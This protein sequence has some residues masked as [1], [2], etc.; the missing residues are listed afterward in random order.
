MGGTIWVFGYGSLIYRPGFVYS[1]RV[2]GYI[3]DYKRVFYQGSTD[4]RGTQEFPGR[5]VTLEPLQGAVTWGV[6]YALSG[7]PAEQEAT[8]QYLEE[9]EKQYDVRRVVDLMGS[10][11]TVFQ[12]PPPSDF[13][14][15]VQTASLKA[16]ADA[17]TL[18]ASLPGNA[19]SNT[20]ADGCA[21]EGRANSQL[22]TT[23]AMLQ[24]V[25]RSGG[26]SVGSA[27]TDSCS[28]LSQAS[29][30]GGSNSTGA[31]SSEESDSSGGGG[32]NNNM[33]GGS[34]VNGTG[35]S[36]SRSSSDVVLVEGALVY[37]ASTDTTRNVN[38]LGP[39]TLS[40][41]ARQVAGATG[42]SGPNCEYV[43]RL[44]ENM[45]LAA[46]AAAPLGAACC[47]HSRLTVRVVP[48]GALSPARGPGRVSLT[49]F[50]AIDIARPRL[51]LRI[52]RS[53]SHSG[54][55]ISLRIVAIA[56]LTMAAAFSL[57]TATWPA[58]DG[59][60]GAHWALVFRIPY[61]ASGAILPPHWL[62][63]W[64][65]HVNGLAGKLAFSVFI[66]ASTGASSG[67]PYG[68][69]DLIAGRAGAS[70]GDQ[71]CHPPSAVATFKSPPM[72]GE[73]LGLGRS[74]YL[75]GLRRVPARQASRTQVGVADKRYFQGLASPASAGVCMAFVW[76]ADKTGL[77]GVEFCFITPVVAVITGLLMVSRFRY[78]S[79]K[80]LPLGERGRVPFGWMVRPAGGR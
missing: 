42:P 53:R 67:V 14:S 10:L 59:V 38:Y 37:I 70:A 40:A 52:W 24:N 3:R 31:L 15:V 4:H 19:A 1:A 16:S 6:A 65:H 22:S 44:A 73:E 60:A 36:S 66:N 50:S 18:P 49:D 57:D 5:T 79:F 27:S 74:L 64:M 21:G 75:R 32:S 30:S 29:L 69:S 56:W 39:A 20:V 46:H 28:T 13:M 33:N 9:R 80:S 34:N 78:F 55:R 8:L 62:P 7:T 58:A 47:S 12:P 35:S 77:P 54:K 25:G 26:P 48:Q 72:W 61:F 76:T 71:T 45:R 2:P 11:N 68:I 43:F 51:S 23:L 41:I 17:I 63:P